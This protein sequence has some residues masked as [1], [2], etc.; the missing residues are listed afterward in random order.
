MYIAMMPT[1]VR[2]I[3]KPIITR[4]ASSDITLKYVRIY[5]PIDEI[6]E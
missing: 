6:V 5:D 2:T 1:P 4:K 3:V